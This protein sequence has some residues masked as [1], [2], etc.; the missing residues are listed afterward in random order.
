MAIRRHARRALRA[1]AL[2]ILSIA[3]LLAV[4]GTPAAAAPPPYPAVLSAATPPVLAA[5]TSS[6]GVKRRA[7]WKRRRAVVRF[8]RA[9]LG[10]PYRWGGAGPNGYDCSGLT[11][12]AWARA[13]RS[14]PHSSRMQFRSTRRVARREMKIGDLLFYGRPIH[15]V[16]IYVGNGKMIEAPRRGLN[17]RRV[18]ANRSGRVGIG[19][20]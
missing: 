10:K 5:T 18:S 8:A 12:A 7:V 4:L 16:A 9:Q 14:L 17:V 3:L 20:P 6:A 13:G 15:H 2:S 11:S 19:R 1:R